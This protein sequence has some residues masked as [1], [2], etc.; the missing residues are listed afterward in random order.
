MASST[1]AS[2][3]LIGSSNIYRFYNPET[4]NDHHPYLLTRCT[5]SSTLESNLLEVEAGSIVLISVLENFIQDAVVDSGVTESDA[6]A[7]ASTGKVVQEAIQKALV[8]INDAALRTIEDGNRFFVVEPINRIKPDWYSINL[9]NTITIF[10]NQFEALCVAPNVW[11]IHASPL[12]EQKFIRDGVHLTEDSGKTFISTILRNVEASISSVNIASVSSPDLSKPPPTSFH[13][14]AEAL[15]KR[16]ATSNVESNTKRKRKFTEPWADDSQ[17]NDEDVGVE[18]AVGNVM[19]PSNILDRMLSEI[20]A[21]K[22]GIEDLNNGFEKR[23]LEDNKSFAA[24]REEADFIVNKSKL[25]RVVV[26]GL[27]SKTP[28]P[29][30]KSERIQTLKALVMDQF[31]KIK[32]DFDGSITFISH[33]NFSGDRIPAVECRMNSVEKATE[34]RKECGRIRKADKSKAN[35]H[36]FITNCVTAT[37]RVRIEI[38]SKISMRLN[39]RKSESYCITFE[40]RPILR[41]KHDRLGWKSFFYVEAI[42]KFS[43]V[44]RK[45]DML[46]AYSK[47][48]IIRE[49][50]EQI[51]IILKEKEARGAGATR[52]SWKG[53]A[54]ST[55]ANA[56]K[57]PK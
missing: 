33:L 40:P 7:D 39:E 4:F 47:A 42:E 20:K 13:F 49:P 2:R 17:N 56:T 23:K 50:L 9:D 19:I 31:V 41:V 27:T 14:A 36:V 8:T 5:R 11:R 22:T 30:I 21:N 10:E 15:R 32:P 48:S 37:T 16:D 12:A 53:K 34:I 25:D 52:M 28:L 57:I 3:T 18:A 54:P 46:G 35:K 43:Y 38:L 26:F 51:F 45:E 44:L 55:G 24:L 6:V 1:L 29:V